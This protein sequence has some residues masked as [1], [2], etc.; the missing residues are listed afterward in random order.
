[1]GTAQSVDISLP[2][3]RLPMGT[4]QSVDISLPQTPLPLRTAHSAGISVSY[5]MAIDATVP[6]GS[7]PY[8]DLKNAY[9]C[10][11]PQL[12]LFLW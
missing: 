2:Q 3:T 12:E 11:G 6:F 10:G 5:K 9:T 1:M 7:R 4:T 8:G